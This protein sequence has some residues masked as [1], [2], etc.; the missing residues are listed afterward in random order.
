MSVVGIGTDLVSIERLTGALDRHGSALYERL[1]TERERAEAPPGREPEHFAGRFAA[2]EAVLKAIG[3]GWS[4][5]VTWHDVE[6]LRVPG[7]APELRL[8]GVAAEI[9]ARQGARRWHLSLTHDAGFALA[10]AVAAQA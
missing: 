8:T 7:G 6:T 5:G 9:A 3:T 10:F 2:K 1:F 4:G